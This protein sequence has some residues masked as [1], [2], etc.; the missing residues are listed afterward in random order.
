LTEGD[1]RAKARVTVGPGPVVGGREA[2]LVVDDEP[3]LRLLMAS[4]LQQAGYRVSMAADGMEATEYLS[5]PS[6]LADVVLLDLN[7][8]RRN[9]IE[10]FKAVRG[11]RPDLKFVFLTGNLTPEAQAELAVH[12]QF[13]IL[14]KPSGLPD[15]SLRLRQVLDEE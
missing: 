2:V 11:L 4:V 15:I 12:G 7:M 5:K 3:S 13:H 1:R 9:G 8:P 14:N 10:T 6:N